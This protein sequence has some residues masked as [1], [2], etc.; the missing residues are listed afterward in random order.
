M[1]SSLLEGRIAL[2]KI[3]LRASGPLASIWD[4]NF[5]RVGL[6][7]E[8][9]DE[10]LHVDFVERA[11]AAQGLTQRAKSERLKVTRR[12]LESIVSRIEQGPQPE[13]VPYLVL[14]WGHLEMIDIAADELHALREMIGRCATREGAMAMLQEIGAPSVVHPL[15]EVRTHW[16][17]PAAI[18]AVIGPVLANVQARISAHPRVGARTRRT[19][20]ALMALAQAVRQRGASAEVNAPGGRA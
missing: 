9:P 8:R 20:V 16:R 14:G 13:Q 2:D 10:R 5:D 7:W 19:R 15:M 3:L 18:L 11:E 6:I 4:C 17:Q 12:K 1:S